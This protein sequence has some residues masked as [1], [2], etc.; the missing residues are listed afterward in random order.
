MRI[1]L[2]DII[3]PYQFAFVSDCMVRDNILLVY[4]LLRN[5]HGDIGTPRCAIK[6]DITKAYDTFY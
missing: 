5:Y 1:V 3:I 4:E 2:P 6:V